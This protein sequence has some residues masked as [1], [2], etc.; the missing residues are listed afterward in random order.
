MLQYSLEVTIR[1]I[2][3]KEPFGQR[4]YPRMKTDPASRIIR[5]LRGLMEITSNGFPRYTEV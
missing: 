5:I 3:G 1:T 2:T 4:L